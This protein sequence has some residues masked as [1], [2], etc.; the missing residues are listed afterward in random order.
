MVSD[1]FIAMGLMAIG[2]IVDSVN[3]NKAIKKDFNNRKADDLVGFGVLMQ[4]EEIRG[5][6][7]KGKYKVQKVSVAKAASS[8]NKKCF[9]AVLR[10]NADGVLHACTVPSSRNSPSVGDC[11]PIVSLENAGS[12]FL[13]RKGTS[14]AFNG[15]WMDE[16]YSPCLPDVQV[17][18]SLTVVLADG[19]RHTETTTAWVERLASQPSFAAMLGYFPAVKL[20]NMVPGSMLYF[21]TEPLNCSGTIIHGQA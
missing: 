16:K 3:L 15:C 21:S 5:Y 17:E 12:Y 18:L 10:C 1:T 4:T 11:T 20:D 8:L 7:E 6:C 2:S 13:S 19:Q 14:W 9:V